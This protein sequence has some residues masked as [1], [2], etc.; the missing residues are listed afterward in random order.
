MTKYEKRINKI[1]LNLLNKIV[2][3]HTFIVFINKLKNTPNLDI[4]TLNFKTLV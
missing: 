1:V 2:N 4:D 3:I